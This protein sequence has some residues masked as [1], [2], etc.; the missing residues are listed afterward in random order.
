VAQHTQ[1]EKNQIDQVAN[2]H[3]QMS[4]DITAGLGTLHGE[5]QATMSGASSDMTK[6]LEQV[7]TNWKNNVQKVV[8]DNL[9]L[10]AETMHKEANNQEQQDTDNT[11]A[12]NNTV[13]AV[14]SFL[15][16]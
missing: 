14:G 10:M 2:K 3:T 13:S 11:R 15:G 9:N 12:I 6:A 5:I 16:G 4:Q 8:L 1:F 7:Y